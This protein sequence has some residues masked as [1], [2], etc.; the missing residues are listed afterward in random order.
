MEFD[1]LKANRLCESIN[2]ASRRAFWPPAD[3][4]LPHTFLMRSMPRIPRKSTFYRNGVLLATL[5]KLCG[6]AAANGPTVPEA[7]SYLSE[8][9]RAGGARFR[10][11]SQRSLKVTDYY[12]GNPCDSTVNYLGSDGSSGSVEIRWSN[13]TG[14]DNIENWLRMAGAIDYEIGSHSGTLSSVTFVAP[15][16]ITAKRMAH[17]SSLL[18]NYCNSGL[19]SKFN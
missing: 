10:S 8:I 16:E 3:E 13:I 19:G 4:D 1:T 12:S 2:A 6:S 17:A 5:V 18:M 7:H 9:F 14:V 15:D 11:T